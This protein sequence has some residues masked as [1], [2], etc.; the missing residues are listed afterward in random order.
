MKHLHVVEPTLESDAGHC[1]SFVGSIVRTRPVD[2]DY[3]IT[4]WADGSADLGKMAAG[5]AAVIPHFS[6]RVRRLQAISLY[7]TI[8]SRGEI[9]FI[10]TGGRHDLVALALAAR[11]LVRPGR[12]YVFVH[13]M[14]ISPR[15]MGMLRWAAA[16]L[17][18]IQIL[19]PTPSVSGVL[20][21]AGFTKVTTVAY[22]LEAGVM[23]PGPSPFAGLLFAGAPRKDK[24]VGHVADY[25]EYLAGIGADLP[26]TVQSSG[27]HYGKM[28]PETESAIERLRNSGYEKLTLQPETLAWNEY[29]A[30][31]PGTICLQP[32]RREDFADRIS[33]VTLDALGAGAPVIVPSGTWMARTVERFGS[34][35]V[36]DDI[37]P[38]KIQA[39]VSLLAAAYGEYSQRALDAGRILKTEHDPYNILKLVTGAPR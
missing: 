20:K 13:W 33:G 4:I 3:Q 24:G 28:E 21:E 7:R 12:V 19:T 9:L 6:R 25:V 16:R 1:A 14:K 26:V 30:G 11:R 39:A 23:Q 38:E 15:K 17:P 10:P 5:N 37:S 32:Y 36:L 22:P 27:T 18:H 29:T 34:G 35:V 2:A 31:F 8:L